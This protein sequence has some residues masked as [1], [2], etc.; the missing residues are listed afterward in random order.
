MLLREKDFT[1]DALRRDGQVEYLRQQIKEARRERDTIATE[2]QGQLSLATTAGDSLRGAITRLTSERNAARADAASKTTECLRLQKSIDNLENVL[3]AFES[4]RE[5]AIDA[6]RR[7]KDQAVEEKD[8]EIRQLQDDVAARGK[9]IAA[10]EQ[11]L[12][13]LSRLRGELN[14]AR[15]LQAA[16]QSQQLLLQGQLNEATS[17]LIASTKSATETLIDRQLV[18]NT[19]VQYFTAPSHRK[20]DVLRL[21]ASILMLNEADQVKVRGVGG[22]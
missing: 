18:A 10:Q 14:V 5:D 22:I 20:E 19:F 9:T 8:A 16:A 3:A 12:K 7:E 2:L 1:D 21:L 15:G 6:V 13:E 17:K 4:E 11:E